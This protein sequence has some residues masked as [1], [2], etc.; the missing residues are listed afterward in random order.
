MITTLLIDIEHLEFRCSPRGNDLYLL[1]ARNPNPRNSEQGWG[2][3]E[4]CTYSKPALTKLKDYLDEFLN[5]FKKENP[6]DLKFICIEKDKGYFEIYINKTQVREHS[7][8][9]LRRVNFDKVWFYPIYYNSFSKSD[10]LNLRDHLD[11]F[12]NL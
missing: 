1:T 8:T 7:W 9:Q 12:L 5:N 10:L 6:S 3:I 2:R 4:D 11:E